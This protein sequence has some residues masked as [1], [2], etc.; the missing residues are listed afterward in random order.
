MYNR[1]AD[2]PDNRLADPPEWIFSYPKTGRT[3][4]RYMLAHVL[5][6]QYDIP[7][8]N[9]IVSAYRVVPADDTAAVHYPPEQAYPFT[10]AG[11][12]PKIGVS[13]APNLPE[14]DANINPLLITRD[15]RDTI[16]SHWFHLQNHYNYKGDIAAFVRDSDFG[17]QGYLDYHAS[18]APH[19]GHQNVITYEEMKSDPLAGMQRVVRHFRIPLSTDILQNAVMIGS[20]ANM[21][22]Q[23]TLHGV[24]LPVTNPQ[25]SDAR[26]VRSGQVGGYTKHLSPADL[27]YI[28]ERVQA[29]RTIVR[30]LLALTGYPMH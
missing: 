25:D 26:R 8:G 4:V 12:A 3:W 20:F 22:A 14:S 6:E 24:S 1:L 17:I 18:W 9:D 19:I 16:V 27:S 7:E 15:P 5:M 10:Y 13:H 23:E 11:M 29:S 28:D 21:G 2:P 30:S